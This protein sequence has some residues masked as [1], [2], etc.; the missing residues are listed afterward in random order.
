MW[1]MDNFKN[2]IKNENERRT[3]HHYHRR[4]SSTISMSRFSFPSFFIGTIIIF[5]ISLDSASALST[6]QIQNIGSISVQSSRF[7]CPNQEERYK[8]KTILYAKKKKRESN[9]NNKNED[10]KS[11]PPKRPNKSTFNKNSSN[12]NNN[13]DQKKKPTQNTNILEILDPYKAGK[14]LRQTLDS[15]ILGATG[16]SS[17]RR[18]IYYLDDRFTDRADAP[19]FAERNPLFDRLLDEDDEYIPEVLVVGATGEVGRLVARR[20]LLDGRFRVRVLVRDL[21]SKTLNLLG[22]G[23]TYCQGDLSNTESLEYA[24]TDVDKIVFCAG[25][26]RP[27]EDDFLQ[28]FEQYASD[29][30][31]TS[32][33]DD[34][35]EYLDWQ[36]AESIMKVR[37]QLAQQIDCNGMQNL[38]RAYQNVRHADYGTSQS[39]KRS[40]FKFQDRPG[41]FDLFYIYNIGD[42]M[43]ELTVQNS[44]HNN[45]N[46]N[47]MNNNNNDW[48]DYDTSPSKEMMDDTNY[49]TDFGNYNDKMDEF[50][51]DEYEKYNNYNDMDD[52]GVPSYETSQVKTT[53]TK[54]TIGQGSWIKNKFG[55]GVF[56]GRVPSIHAYGGPGES[57]IIS[58]TLSSRDGPESGGIDLSNDFAGFVMRLCADGKN[59]ECFIRTGEYGVE[60]VCPFKTGRKTKNS[61]GSSNHHHHPN[62]K[63][64][65]KFT[66]VRIPFSNFKKVFKNKQ[67]EDGKSLFDGKDIRQIGFR[68]R[69]DQNSDLVDDTTMYNNKSNQQTKKMKWVK[70]YLA[71]SYIKV[72]RSQPEPEFIYLSDSR[73]P[74]KIKNGMVR[75]DLRQLI[76]E[77]DSVTIFDE[78]DVERVTKNPKDR[79]GE[80]VYFKYRGEEILRHSGLR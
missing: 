45:N 76:M 19:I 62:N 54:T 44:D 70:F 15:A 75:H 61:S 59:Y 22:T 14:K 69:G 66:T 67:E 77:E 35:D 11:Q 34:D 4:L 71:F 20:L 28:K 2:N 74:P 79:S 27:D 68:F 30:L 1:R 50:E 51:E 39:A 3:H 17:E 48:S 56:V 55:H 40:L 42:E 57:A 58:S 37:A 24:L 23:V 12:K 29:N 41:D 73:I 52:Y 10:N 65:N 53:K 6:F 64:M 72:Y 7:Q 32:Q 47:N 5:I 80:E 49:G 25:A 18:K 33:Q 26:P 78:K 46:N 31:Y 9:N 8:R 38:V 13:N 36:K 63:S 43:D 21:Y 60:Y 16:L